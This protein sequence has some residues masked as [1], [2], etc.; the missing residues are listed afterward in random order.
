MPSNIRN[1]VSEL[2][3]TN[4]I[5]ILLISVYAVYRCS[6]LYTVEHVMLTF[7]DCVGSSSNDSDTSYPLVLSMSVT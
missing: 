1:T 6:M 3:R 4:I 5:P 7:V 2:P